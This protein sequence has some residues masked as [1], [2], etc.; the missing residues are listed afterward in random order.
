VCQGG[1][2]ELAGHLAGPSLCGSS[3]AF[4]GSGGHSEIS[5]AYRCRCWGH[6]PSQG[7]FKDFGGHSVAQ[8]QS[9]VHCGAPKNSGDQEI[10]SGVARVVQGVQGKRVKRVLG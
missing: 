5:R 3:G 9:G 10:H 2:F 6:S 4:R 1:I 8:G 7:A